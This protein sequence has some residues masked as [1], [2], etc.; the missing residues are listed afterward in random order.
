MGCTRLPSNAD[1]NLSLQLLPQQ[2]LESLAVLGEFFDAF[3]ELVKCHGVLKEGPSEFGLIVNIGDLGDGS[4]GSGS[5][6]VELLG[7]WRAVV[8]E[9][10]QKGRRDGEEIDTSQSLDLS[11][12]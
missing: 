2:R 4:S 1:T 10:L 3:V 5:S 7:D 8:L 6:G 9:L 12:L 11:G